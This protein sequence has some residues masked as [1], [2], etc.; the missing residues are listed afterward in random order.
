MVNFICV[1]QFLPADFP[2]VVYRCHA[3]PF[4]K[5]PVKGGSVGAPK[6]GGDPAFAAMFTERRAAGHVDARDVEECSVYRA[7]MMVQAFDLAVFRHAIVNSTIDHGSMLPDTLE[8]G[9]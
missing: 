5:C 4:Y 6:A 9:H 7:G 3:R 2:A 1:L 8:I